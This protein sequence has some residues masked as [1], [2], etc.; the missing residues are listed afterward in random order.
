[1]C[2]ICIGIAVYGLHQRI[3]R[4]YLSVG[5]LVSSNLTNFLNTGKVSQW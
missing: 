5:T 2:W 1:M 4:Q 3:K